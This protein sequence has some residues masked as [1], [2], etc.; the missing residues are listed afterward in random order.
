VTIDEKPK[1]AEPQA[2][3]SRAIRIGKRKIPLPQNRILRI[4]LGVFFV[5]CGILGFLPVLGFWMVPVGLAVLAV[6]IPV[7]RRAHRRL[8]VTA[9]RWWDEACARLGYP[10]SQRRLRADRNSS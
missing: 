3:P 4:A 10:P 8:T 9:L 5:L 7:A 1:A 6:D 2:S